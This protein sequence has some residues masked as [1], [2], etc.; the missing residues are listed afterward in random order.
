MKVIKNR[1]GVEWIVA[2]EEFKDK[3]SAQLAELGIDTES[4]EYGESCFRADQVAHFNRTDEDMT[5]VSLKNNR[6]FTV[7]VKYDE[8]KDFMLK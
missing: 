7:R 4:F 1:F 8:F 2:D 5:T 3:D 6:W